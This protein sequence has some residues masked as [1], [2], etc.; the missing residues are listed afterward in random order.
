MAVAYIQ[1]TRQQFNICTNICV[2]HVRNSC[3]ANG[4]QHI[5]AAGTTLEG[6]ACSSRIRTRTWW[7]Y[8]TRTSTTIH[9]LT[10]LNLIIVNYQCQSGVAVAAPAAAA[11][12]DDDDNDGNAFDIIIRPSVDY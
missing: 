7:P 2:V 12:V 11:A 10:E 3:V 5:V 9:K 1:T 4:H 6:V 8:S